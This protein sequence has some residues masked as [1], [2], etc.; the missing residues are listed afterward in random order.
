M[1]CDEI[2]NPHVSGLEDGVKQGH[3]RA[4]DQL[5]RNA[6]A[7]SLRS[8]KARESQERTVQSLC[9]GVWG[10][11]EGVGGYQVNVYSI[12]AFLCLIPGIRTVYFP[13]CSWQADWTSMNNAGA[14]LLNL[15]IALFKGCINRSAMDY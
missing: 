6:R 14:A 9:G 4:A 11:G 7:G 3:L 15:L 8:C 10:A 1:C 13:S 12:L 2:G 5:L